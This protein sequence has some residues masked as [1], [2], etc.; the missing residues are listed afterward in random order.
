LEVVV[1]AK[2]EKLRKDPNILGLVEKCTAEAIQKTENVIRDEI[3]EQYS[4]Q[5]EPGMKE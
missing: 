2:I 3:S 1:S 4:Q 5:V